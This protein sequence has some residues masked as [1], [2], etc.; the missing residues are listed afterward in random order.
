MDNVVKKIA[1]KFGEDIVL[2]GNKL[3]SLITTYEKNKKTVGLLNSAI[4]NNIPKKIYDT[5]TMSETDRE[6]KITEICK[7]F[8]RDYSIQEKSAYQVVN[9]FTEA[10]KLTVTKPAPPKPEK[11]KEKPYSSVPSAPKAGMPSTS[12]ASIASV[13]VN[14]TAKPDSNPFES[15]DI[16]DI[17]ARQQK[18]RKLFPL[19][20]MQLKVSK[21]ANIPN[22]LTVIT[23]LIIILG[24][25]IAMIFV[26]KQTFSEQENRMLAK[27]PVFSI[28]RLTQGLFTKDVAK[29]YS[30]QFPL[31]NMFVGLKGIA[32]I[33]LLKNENDGVILGKDNYLITKNPY[34][35]IDQLRTNIDYISAFADAMKQMK[36]PVTLAAAGRSIDA[37]SM[38]LPPAYPKIE[39]E[40]LWKSFNGLAD[41][42]QNIQ[43]LNLLDPLKALIEQQNKG[44]LY[45]R[46]DHHWTT[47]GAYYA[48]VEIMKA[49]NK[50]DGFE[51]QPLSAFN[52]VAATDSFYGTTWSKS[53]M[54]WIKPDTIYYFRYDGDEDFVTT[55]KDTG[56]TFNGFYDLSYLDTKDKYGSF[57]SGNNARVDIT[58]PDAAGRPKLLI[59]KDSFAHCLVPFLAYHYDLVI[60]D[61]RYYT[62]SVAK[63]VYEEGIDRILFLNNM[64]NLS[65]DD[66]F[67]LLQ[68][69]VDATLKA[70]VMD[71][72]P[73]KKIY[74][75]GNPIDDYTI[76]YP[77]DENERRQ[78]YY[79]KAAASLHDMILSKAGVDIKVAEPGDLSVY[80][81][82]DKVIMFT[83][84]GIPS[85]GLMKIATEGNN[86]VFR[87][88]IG[89]D[90]SG[91]A[92]QRFNDK[93]I[94]NGT[95]SFNFGENFIFS[96]V[97]NNVIMILPTR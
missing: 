13:N 72:Y 50:E 9:Y 84:E 44:Q 62:D 18:E 94:K 14:E 89:D 70:Y 83:A 71:Q 35:G 2:D 40:T 3:S 97:G 75:N 17:N 54:K 91:Y 64:E 42:A 76:V 32:E 55:I 65:E 88:N 19:I 85:G 96:D 82:D 92:V 69:G 45:Y 4:R 34:N 11:P 87:C 56:K 78:Q 31:R 6:M 33:S 57:L 49:F 66:T 29:Y 26:P 67:G 39:S 28:D 21:Q 46:T 73:I 59:I 63:L 61:L 23:G 79:V 48:Y 41:Y 38:Y 74:I 37:L 16:S 90:P 1:E 53:G 47:L 52:I 80:T 58:K 27:L 30:D 25:S 86:L 8:S 51:P 43:R 7:Q 36:V 24:L 10:F 15:N 20:E 81:K 77:V 68:Y 12:S 93:Y 60:L 5:R 22:M 95:G